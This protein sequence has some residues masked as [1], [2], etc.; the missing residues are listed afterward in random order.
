MIIY[1]DGNGFFPEENLVNLP[2]PD[3]NDGS[4]A[5]TLQKLLISTVTVTWT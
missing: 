5:A 4:V 1:N 2:L 3:F